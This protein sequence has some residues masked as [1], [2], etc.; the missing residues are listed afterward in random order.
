MKQ[1]KGDFADY[2]LQTV[3]ISVQRS[4]LLS[5]H[6]NFK[7]G[8]QAD[9]FFE[10]DSASRLVKA[11]QAAQE[12]NLPYYVIGGG[13]NL[14]FDDEGYRGLIIKNSAQGIRRL[15]KS[16]EIEVFAGAWL[17][18]MVEYCHQQ[19]LTGF[20]FLAGIPGTVGGAVFGNA[21]AFGENIGNFLKEAFLLNEQGE[22]VKVEPEYFAFDYRFSFLKKRHHLLLKTVFSLRPGESIKIKKKIGENLSKREKK[23]PPSSVAC[24]GSYF[25]NPVFPDGK[26]VAAAYLLDQI[27][28]KNI[29]VGEAAVHPSHSNFIINLGQASCRD[30][31]SLA[32]EL[33]KRVKA[34]FDL[35]LEEEVIYLPA[36]QSML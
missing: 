9:Y 13:Y 33:K 25:K 3:G 14:L 27:G 4:M 34:R 31:L 21:G 6:S 29:R 2:F 22:E 15:G 7:I 28:A 36:E 12:F 24:A 35:E 5:L 17:R 18:D 16:S 10:A 20:E 1:K 26:R 32:E 23:H 8:G 11:V 19:S 30:I